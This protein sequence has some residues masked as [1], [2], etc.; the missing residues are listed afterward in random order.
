MG[1]WSCSW[2]WCLNKLPSCESSKHCDTRRCRAVVGRKAI[3]QSLR[4][5]EWSLS[6]H[7]EI[8]VERCGCC[9]KMS[10]KTR[11]TRKIRKQDCFHRH[12]HHQAKVVEITTR[13]A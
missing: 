6:C 13:I 5:D 2:T 11:K 9:G 12:S 10:T 7:C 4:S 8:I 1:T 3:A